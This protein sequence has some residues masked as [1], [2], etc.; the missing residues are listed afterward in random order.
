MWLPTIVW[1]IVLGSAILFV[2][3]FFWIHPPG[4]IKAARQRP[5]QGLTRARQPENRSAR[6]RTHR[7]SGYG[8]VRQPW[9]D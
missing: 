9:I 8:M 2:I 3:D 1:T 6:K 5:P 4:W 7:G